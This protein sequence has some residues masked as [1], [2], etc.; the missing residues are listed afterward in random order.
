MLHV[1]YPLCDISRVHTVRLRSIH[2][3]TIMRHLTDI[4]MLY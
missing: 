2:D 1:S 4:C 3:N